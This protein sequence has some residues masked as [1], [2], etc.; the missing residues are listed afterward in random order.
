MSVTA[1]E[2]E[3]PGYVEAVIISGPRK[4]EFITLPEAETDLAPHEEKILDSIFS[5]LVAIAEHMAE[6]AKAARI[7]ADS[8]LE[9]LRGIGEER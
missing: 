1:L 7:E 5:E 6:N 4:G 8:M 9:I 2:A 3:V